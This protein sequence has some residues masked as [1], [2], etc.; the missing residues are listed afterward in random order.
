MFYS[1]LVYAGWGS[2]MGV[3]VLVVGLPL[4]FLQRN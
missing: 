3:V 2:I 4:I 1:A